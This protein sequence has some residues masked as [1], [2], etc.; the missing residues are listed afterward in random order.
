VYVHGA[1]L[2]NQSL[3]NKQPINGRVE[4]TSG[5]KRGREWIELGFF[6][7]FFFFLDGN[8]MRK[9]CSYNSLQ[10]SVADSSGFAPEG[11]RFN[12]A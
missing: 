11:F 6:L 12:K 5:L 1:I 8:S 4:G 3:M 10:V 2:L 9:R 7:F